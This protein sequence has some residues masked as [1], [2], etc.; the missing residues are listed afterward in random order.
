[1]INKDEDDEDAEEILLT[2]GFTYMK[3]DICNISACKTNK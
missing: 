1:M 2:T 3:N